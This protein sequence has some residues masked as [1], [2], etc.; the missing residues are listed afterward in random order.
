MKK[1]PDFIGVLLACLLMFKG[2]P[3]LLFSEMW[4]SPK[5]SRA[6]LLTGPDAQWLGAAFVLLGLALVLVFSS[7][8]GLAPK[9]AFTAASA[10]GIFAVV[11]FFLSVFS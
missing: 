1:L 9:R 6:Y 4:V 7:R 5:H 10:V 3:G 8:W 11:A 2:A